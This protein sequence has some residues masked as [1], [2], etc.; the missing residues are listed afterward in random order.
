MQGTKFP[1]NLCVSGSSNKRRYI[2]SIFFYLE[3]K[4]KKKKSILTDIKNNNSQD[5]YAVLVQVTSIP[6]IITTGYGATSDRAAE[7]AAKSIL[8][9]FKTMLHFTK[10][11]AINNNNEEKQRIL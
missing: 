11:D 2:L 7:E 10:P 1:S 3:L 9:M 6:A 4:F 8:Q 5:K